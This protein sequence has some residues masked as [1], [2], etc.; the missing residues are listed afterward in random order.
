MFVFNLV[1]EWQPADSHAKVMEISRKMLA[2]PL[3]NFSRYSGC[4][5]N[6]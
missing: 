1:Y 2:V 3:Q 5:V 4:D 6:V